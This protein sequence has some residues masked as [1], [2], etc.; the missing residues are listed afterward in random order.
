M[1]NKKFETMMFSVVGV[2]AMFLLLV[3]V[4][5]LASLA[6]QRVDLTAEKLYT[7][8]DGS[9]EILHKI[10]G[11]VEIRFYCTRGEKEMPIT[12]K[13]Y[14]QRV[15]DLLSEY[16]QYSNKK[17]VVKH[18]DPKPDSDAEDS[19][20]LDG[21]EG[22]M[23]QSGDR[24]YLGLAV[25]FVGKKVALPFLSPDRE[26][27]L[28]YDIS[29]AIASVLT[30]EKPT[31][32][33]MSSLPIFGTKFNPMMAQMGQQ[34]QPA[35][36]FIDEL[37][38]DYNV[39][40]V[41]PSA[42]KIDDKY[43]VLLVVHPKNLSDQTQ[44]ALD[45]FVLRGG[46]LIALVDPSAIM[47][48]QGGNPMMGSMPGASSLDKLF[49]AWG[50]SMEAGKVVADMNYSTK[51]RGRNGQPQ[52][53][54][55][56]LS[57]TSEALN[58]DDVVTSTLDNLLLPFA[59]SFTGTP[60]AGLTETVL[61]K[62]SP[63]SEMVEGFM[64]QLSGGNIIKDFK[65][66]DKEMPI[67]IRLTGKFKTAFPDGKPKDTKADDKT[68]GDKKDEKKEDAKVEDSLKESKSDNA[69]IL[70]ADVDWIY[71]QFCVQ[72]QNFFGQRIMMPVSGNLN[73]L[74]N[75]VDQFAGDSSLIKVRS[76][77]SLNRP[78]TVVNKME[79]VARD[80]YQ[81]KI[82]EL[83]GNLAETQKRL[84]ELQQNKE[85]GQRFILSPEQQ[86]EIEKFRKQEADTNK[87]LKEE[88]KKLHR[89]IDSLQNRL[90]LAN[91]AAMPLL[92]TLFGLGLYFVKRKRTAA[93]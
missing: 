68:D 12:L 3:A 58:K 21:V 8:S 49:K 1:K 65:A 55:A 40:Q 73:L 53:N 88:R 14:A 22:Q 60:T 64:A 57:L 86:K 71:D 51:L 37:K 6:K 18:L 38:Q 15:D 16:Q 7:L 83:E 62:S 26:R 27:L 66:S 82:K 90:K 93:R 9:K 35:W 92:V 89:E 44:Y 29:R 43:K 20:N 36:A 17:L 69:V 87:Q 74:Q 30:D 76:R 54:P 39:E 33:V 63:K 46:K 81:S 25:E 77:A 50:I 47:D 13:T 10:D 85:K 19:A 79:A 80:R 70:F 5:Y 34:Q 56:F 67:A 42:D 45:Q 72:I 48:S 11:Q 2:I 41:E 75:V 4:N 91:I 78:F 61:I 24:I 23:L 59:G 28:E 84:N 32:G 52:D 31:I